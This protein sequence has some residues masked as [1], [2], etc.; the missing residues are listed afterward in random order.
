MC[1]TRRRENL[2]GLLINDYPERE[3]MV[4][5]KVGKNYEDFKNLMEKYSR[6]R[7]F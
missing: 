7:W 2:K 5:I 4:I 1:E 3:Y 6:D